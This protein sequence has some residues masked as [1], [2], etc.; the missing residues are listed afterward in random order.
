MDVLS[1]RFCS[2][3][4]H[5]FH[6]GPMAEYRGGGQFWAW[7]SQGL[8]ILITKHKGNG[9]FHLCETESIY[10]VLENIIWCKMVTYL[11]ALIF[12]MTKV[13]TNNKSLTRFS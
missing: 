10:V 7:A 13:W 11:M 9:V 8:R 6:M 1:K 12:V 5:T 4:P 3:T 2:K